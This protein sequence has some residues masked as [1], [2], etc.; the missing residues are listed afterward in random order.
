ME[1]PACL[2][3]GADISLPLRRILSELVQNVQWHR[4]NFPHHKQ[5][6][7]VCETPLHQRNR[8]FIIYRQITSSV[9]DFGDLGTVFFM[10]VHV[11]EL[12]IWST[13]CNDHSQLQINHK[14]VHSLSRWNLRLEVLFS[15]DIDCTSFNV[16]NLRNRFQFVYHWVKFLCPYKKTNNIM[17]QFFFSIMF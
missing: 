11:Y 8:K 15:E 16:F 13:Y 17:L 4:S 14:Y 9:D 6:H 3:T 12:K 2:R 5:C 1:R 7:R 10:T